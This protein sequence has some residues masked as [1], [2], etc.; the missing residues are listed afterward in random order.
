VGSCSRPVLDRSQR[1]RRSADRETEFLAS[2]SSAERLRVGKGKF[3]I[4]ECSVGK[5][6]AAAR[7]QLR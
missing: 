7:G 3:A 2:L 5:E 4:F 1:K 6:V